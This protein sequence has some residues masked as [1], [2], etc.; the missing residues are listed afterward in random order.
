MQRRVADHFK[1]TAAPVVVDPCPDEVV[2]IGACVA[3]P[4]APAPEPKV[5]APP[6]APAVTEVLAH[7]VGIRTGFDTMHPVVPRGSAL[8]VTATVELV[9]ADTLSHIEVF[10]GDRT[11]SASA[12]THV[13]TVSMTD[14]VAVGDALELQIA[15]SA[16]NL[17]DVQIYNG[18]TART[19]AGQVVR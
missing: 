11:E 9:A 1:G 8:P 2:A 5:P 7:T 4:T 12:N 15:L 14:D 17:I 3:H 10:E 18:R 6:P 16:D 13:G 19:V